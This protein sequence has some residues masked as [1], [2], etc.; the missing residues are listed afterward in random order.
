MLKY[1]S[2]TKGQPNGMFIFYSLFV[3]IKP[4][5]S[6]KQTHSRP[7][8]LHPDHKLC[9]VVRHG[10]QINHPC[11]LPVQTDTASTHERHMHSNSRLTMVLP[12]KIST[13]LA[14]FP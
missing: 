3:E 10:L 6:Y 7:V 4:A 5:Y 9:I 11:W 14:P 13:A 12:G 1:I 2:R 8:S